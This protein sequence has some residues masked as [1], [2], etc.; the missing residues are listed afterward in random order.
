MFGLI[1]YLMLIYKEKRRAK[2]KPAYKVRD[3]INELQYVVKVQPRHDRV[4]FVPIKGI[5]ANR[6]DVIIFKLLYT[7]TMGLASKILWHARK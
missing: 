3:R 5:L 7:K 2:M 1:E 4:C 6:P